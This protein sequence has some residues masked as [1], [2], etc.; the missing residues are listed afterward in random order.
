[1]G[2]HQRHA[3]GR[4][5][6]GEDAR[7]QLRIRKRDSH[8]DSIR[9]HVPE[10]F[11]AK[12]V[13]DDEPQQAA[14]VVYVTLS[15]TF[16]GPAMYS[17]LTGDYNP[18]VTQAPQTTARNGAPNFFTGE[19]E[20]RTTDDENAV[21]TSIVVPQSSNRAAQATTLAT[22]TSAGASRIGGTP[23]QATRAASS[24]AAAA[25]LDSQDTGMTAGGKAGLAIGIIAAFA[26]LV[27]AALLFLNKRKKSIKKGDALN[28]KHGSFADVGARRA[29]ANGM[30]GGMSGG[31][32]IMAAGAAGAAGAGA[33]AANKR[34]SSMTEKVPASLRSTRTASTAPRLSLRP[35][36]QF[37]PMLGDNKSNGTVNAGEKRNSARERTPANN[38]ADPF[39]DGQAASNPFDEQRRSNESLNGAA[40]GA[41]AAANG[42]RHSPKASWEG[43]EAA[44]PRSAHFGTAAAVPL[45]AGAAGAQAPRQPNN[46]HRVQLDFKPSMDDELELISGALVRLLH[47]YDD[48]WALCITMD[49][50][51]QGVAPRTCLSKLPVKPRP[52]G[53]P[54][55][56][57]SPGYRPVPPNGAPRGPLPPQNGNRPAPNGA[58]GAMQPRPLTPQSIRTP[59]PTEQ[60][61]PMEQPSTSGSSSTS[62]AGSQVPKRK[63]VGQAM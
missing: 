38:G 53:P 2:L 39:A 41:A 25:S 55:Q 20:S 7:E 50:S 18:E 15:Q 57:G 43:S 54:P 49:R 36:T 21:E 56:Q 28:E 32:P 35:V 8:G 45:A 3:H 46:V 19:A 13:E 60:Q 40:A 37:L 59:S 14:S 42:Q 10:G 61:R 52:Q 4:V 1:M 34:D 16:E 29:E 24:T 9:L 63:P 27:G 48:G 31:M 58:P 26:V 17:T 44:T 62:P 51:K 6:H 11:Q 5:F 33:A 47:E 12:Q 23:I 30:A 22:A